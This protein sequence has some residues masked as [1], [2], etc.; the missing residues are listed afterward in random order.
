M[1][2]RLHIR[3]SSGVHRAGPAGVKSRRPPAVTG[4]SRC[5]DPRD[6]VT[7]PPRDLAHPL[8]CTVSRRSRAQVTARPAA[9]VIRVAPHEGACG[10]IPIPSSAVK[11]H[12]GACTVFH[13]R[14]TRGAALVGTAEPAR[15]EG[16]RDSPRSSARGTA[17]PARRAGASPLPPTCHPPL[18]PRRVSRAALLVG[19]PGPA[20]HSGDSDVRGSS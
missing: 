19:H 8:G 15:R 3:V 6:R 1:V 14:A 18:P 7:V 17:R 13:R 2:L 5:G 12:C 4:R 16:E 10:S 9:T 11:Q 20:R